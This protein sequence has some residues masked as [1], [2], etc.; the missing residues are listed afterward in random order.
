MDGDEGNYMCNLMIEDFANS[1]IRLDL[2]S[3]HIYLSNYIM[4]TVEKGGLLVKY[5]ETCLV[6]SIPWA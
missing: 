2:T 1:T 6:V 3:E 5:S 4:T